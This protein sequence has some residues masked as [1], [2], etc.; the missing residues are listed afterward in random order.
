[1]LHLSPVTMDDK[2]ATRFI[3]A[4]ENSWNMFAFECLLRKE[5]PAWFPLKKSPPGLSPEQLVL[6]D[7]ERW[8]KPAE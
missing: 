3:K 6:M 5:P 7:W 2:F 8:R 4:G 1:M